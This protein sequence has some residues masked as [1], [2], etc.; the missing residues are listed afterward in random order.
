MIA[1]LIIYLIGF[2]GILLIGFVLM[3]WNINYIE[4]KNRQYLKAINSV[5]PK[6]KKWLKKI[7]F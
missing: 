5:K 4:H 3:R 2:V 1:L 7:M 6:I